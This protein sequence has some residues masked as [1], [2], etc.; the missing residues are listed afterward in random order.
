MMKVIQQKPKRGRPPKS[1]H[2]HQDTKQALIRSGVELITERGYMTA[3]IDSILKRVGIPKGSFY[4][5]FENKEA[6]GHAILENY[7]SYFA[8][9]LNKYLNNQTISPLERI[10][11]FYLDAKQGMEKYHFNRG[12]LVGN[13]GQEISTIPHSFRQRLNEIFLDWQHCI[14]NCLTE[15]QLNGDIAQSLNSQT[16]AYS[17]WIGWEGAVMRA[18]LIKNAEPMTIFINYFLNNLDYK[19]NLGTDHSH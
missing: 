10:Y 8:H 17:F 2:D 11:Q 4:Y 15:A 7:A 5:Y 12:C 19:P 18:K 9:K 13:L 16:L 3:D 6:F 1:T 14:A